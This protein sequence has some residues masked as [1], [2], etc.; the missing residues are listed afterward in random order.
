MIWLIACLSI[1]LTFWFLVA[2]KPRQKRRQVI[3]VVCSE[4]SGFEVIDAITDE[5]VGQWPEKILCR[6]CRLKRLRDADSHH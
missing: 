6:K 1:C 5:T 3:A 2:E 4:C